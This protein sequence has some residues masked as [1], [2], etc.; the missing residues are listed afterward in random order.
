MSALPLRAIV[1]AL[2]LACLTP[3]SAALLGGPDDPNKPTIRKT[4]ENIGTMSQELRLVEK[5]LEALEGSVAG[6][7]KSVA[8]I[9]K[10]VASLDTTLK[11]AAALLK[12]EGLQ[13]LARG[14]GEMAFEQ[15]RGLIVLATACAA[16]LILLAFGLQVARHRLGIAKP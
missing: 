11:P 7:D 6:L 12:P 13:A 10:S 16:G 3:A 2:A 4:M 8:G 1:T 5:R 14:V 15:V 9:D